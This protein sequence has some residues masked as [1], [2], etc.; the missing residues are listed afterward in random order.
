MVTNPV[1]GCLPITKAN[2]IWQA[3]QIA[4][5]VPLTEHVWRQDAEPGTYAYHC[6]FHGAAGGVGIGGINALTVACLGLP[7][8]LLLSAL[9]LL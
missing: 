2:Q 5:A 4:S 1:C 9:R 3:E 7:G 8:Y 6:L